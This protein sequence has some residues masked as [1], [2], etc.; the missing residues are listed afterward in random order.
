VSWHQF[1]AEEPRLAE[2][3]RE[4]LHG[5]IAYLATLNAKGSPRL[6]PVTP[7]IDGRRLLV[8]MEP[9][10][11]KGHDMRRDGR[12]A[13]HCGVEDARGGSGEVLVRGR[14]HAQPPAAAEAAVAD[15]AH[16]PPAERYVMFELEL[17]EVLIIRG[18]SDGPVRTRWHSRPTAPP[19]PRAG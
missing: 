15:A 10:S 18:G 7:V 1:V 3:V 6:H 11:P 5:R 9:N 13:L 17:S 8:F 14:A 19:A 16:A 12:Y 2:F 4:R